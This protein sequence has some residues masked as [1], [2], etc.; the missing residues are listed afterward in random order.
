MGRQIKARSVRNGE[1]MCKKG[2]ARLMY[3]LTQGPNGTRGSL[4]LEVAGLSKSSPERAK[5]ECG[6]MED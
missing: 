3:K 1:G 5:S 2:Q 6:G 4:C